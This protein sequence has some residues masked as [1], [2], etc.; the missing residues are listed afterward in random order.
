MVSYLT[1]QLARRLW[2]A[3][4]VLRVSGGRTRVVN[5]RG[6]ERVLLRNAEDRPRQV[7]APGESR[8]DRR[9][10]LVRGFQLGTLATIGAFPLAACGSGPAS[11]SPPA[12]SPGKKSLGQL[13]YRLSWIKNAEFAGSYIA[14]TKG[15]YSGEGFTSVNLI[16]G[17]P[18]ATPMEA[19]VATGKA[20]VSVSAPD[21]TGAAIKMG[22]PLKII[23]AQYQKNPFAVM[24]MADKPIRVPEDMYGKKIGIQVANETVWNSFIRA[25]KLDGSKIHKVPVQFDPLPLT[26]GTVDGWFSIITNEPAELRSKGFKVTTFLFADYGYPL[27]FDTYLARTDTIK[28]NPAILKAFLRG[29]IRGWKD[30]I[31]NPA[32]G[33]QLAVSKYGKGLGLDIAEQTLQS[34]AE[35]Q[36]ISTADTTK[37][38]LFTITDQL[39]EENIATLREGGLKL[40]ADQLFDLSLLREIYQEQPSLV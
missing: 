29:E 33:A 16:S 8:I 15:Y 18:S 12:S 26:Q 35:N 11:S 4:T 40:T 2:R 32:E 3:V 37:N 24:S 27:V 14:D 22:A 17:G 30:N 28:T 6:E 36:L 7:G 23:G 9:R 19:D 39:V 34:S 20:L 1:P 38:G 13:N 21:L 5:E 10:V 25:A 31:A